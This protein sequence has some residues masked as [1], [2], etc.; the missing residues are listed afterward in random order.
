M[1]LYLITAFAFYCLR[2]AHVGSRYVNDP[3][4]DSG[5]FTGN[6][7]SFG[8]CKNNSA[9]RIILPVDTYVHALL[10]KFTGGF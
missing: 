7:Q 2:N 4:C 8:V 1:K 10:S 3:F 9:L 5:G 6:K